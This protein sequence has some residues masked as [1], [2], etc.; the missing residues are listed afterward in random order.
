MSNPT[1]LSL[2]AIVLGGISQPSLL[3]F[4]LLL[5]Q[6]SE[7]KEGT[8]C[9]GQVGGAGASGRRELWLPEGGLLSR[10]QQMTFHILE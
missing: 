10:A 1:G 8:L 6:A 4:S 5:S 2:E 9:L 7:G 3:G